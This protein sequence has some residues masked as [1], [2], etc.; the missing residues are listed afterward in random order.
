MSLG[1][2]GTQPAAS[3]SSEEGGGEAVLVG[4]RE[5]LPEVRLAP[6]AALRLG[7]ARDNDVAAGGQEVSAHHCLLERHADG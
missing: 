6:G 7:R 5:G 1:A 2:A 4:L 3:G